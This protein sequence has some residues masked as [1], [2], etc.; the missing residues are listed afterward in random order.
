M[1]DEKGAE[2]ATQCEAVSHVSSTKSPEST[3]VSANIPYCML[4]EEEDDD[5]VPDIDDLAIEDDE[6]DEVNF[7]VYCV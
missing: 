5:D 2:Q 7:S 3:N 4:Q 6:A 1:P